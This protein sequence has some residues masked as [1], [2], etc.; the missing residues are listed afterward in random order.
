MKSKATQD[1]L[2][3]T[4]I[5]EALSL[6]LQSTRPLQSSTALVALRPSKL[7]MAQVQKQLTSGINPQAPDSILSMWQSSMLMSKRRRAMEMSWDNRSQEKGRREWMGNRI[8]SMRIKMP[9]RRHSI[10]ILLVEEVE[11]RLW[12][13]SS[14]TWSLL[15]SLTFEETC[16]ELILWVWVQGKEVE[17]GAP[18]QRIHWDTRI[19]AAADEAARKMIWEWMKLIW[20]LRLLLLIQLLTQRQD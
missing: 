14:V 4:S 19:E 5:K 17:E 20:L 12:E 7:P 9:F 3:V 13:T 15:R 8:N 1:S 18:H 11:E 6:K 10:I 16:S 2:I